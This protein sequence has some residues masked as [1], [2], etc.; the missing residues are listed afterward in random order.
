M[1]RITIQGEGVGRHAGDALTRKATANVAFKR[2]VATFRIVLET[3]LA[4]RRSEQGDEVASAFDQDARN[5]LAACIA[6]S[7]ETSK[8]RPQPLSCDMVST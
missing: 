5:A 3:T 6:L 2:L 8:P 1:L 7:L 4:L